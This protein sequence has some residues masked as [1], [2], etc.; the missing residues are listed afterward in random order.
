MMKK[1]SVLLG[2]AILML[3]TSLSVA[4]GLSRAEED[5]YSTGYSDAV[6]DAHHEYGHGY[7]PSCPSGHSEA[8]CQ[9]YQSGYAVGWRSVITTESQTQSSAVPNTLQNQTQSLQNQTQSSAVPNTLQNQTQ[10]LQNQTQSLQNQTQ[11]SAVPNTLQNQT[12]SLQNQ[13]Q[14]SAVPNTLQ[15]QTQ[16]SAVP[17]TATSNSPSTS[18]NPSTGPI[19]FGLLIIFLVIIYA[20]WKLRHKGG[21][22]KRRR[23]FSIAVMQRT[24][25]RQDNR[26]ANCHKWRGGKPMDFDHKNG[27]R[28]DNSESNCQAL[29]PDCHADKTRR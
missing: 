7:D 27:D 28:S 15:N 17:N 10:S 14:S 22:Y 21:K 12:Q 16:S 3:V 2:L 6:A 24:L 23:D 26:C 8:Y 18:T 19:G 20:V 1:T 4:A 29:C 13:T 11:S 25:E 5:A 9:N